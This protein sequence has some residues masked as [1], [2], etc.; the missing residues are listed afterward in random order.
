MGLVVIVEG[1]NGEDGKVIC[2]LPRTCRFGTGE[3]CG[4]GMCPKVMGDIGAPGEALPCW[5]ASL[6]FLLNEGVPRIENGD[7]SPE[8]CLDCMGDWHPE[9]E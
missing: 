9:A 5:L 3:F 8:S 7:E 4:E 1:G 2:R 6:L